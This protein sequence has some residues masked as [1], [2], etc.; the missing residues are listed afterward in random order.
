MNH[1]LISRRAERGESDPWTRLSG[2][3]SARSPRIVPGA[4]VAGFVAPIVDRTTAIAPSPSSTSASVGEEV[5]NVTSSP[6]NGFFA[7]SA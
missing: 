7:C 6:K 1:S 5:M 2:I 3:D 4:D